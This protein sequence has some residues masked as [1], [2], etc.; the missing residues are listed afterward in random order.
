MLYYLLQAVG[1]SS[2]L[3]T[4]IEEF[5]QA[6]ADGVKEYH[7]VYYP[8]LLKAKQSQVCILRERLHRNLFFILNSSHSY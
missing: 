2:L 5:F 7:S 8:Q 6:V 4:G 1:V 3:G